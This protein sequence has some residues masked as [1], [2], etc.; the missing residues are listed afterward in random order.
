MAVRAG[1]GGHTCHPSTTWSRQGGQEFKAIL[2]ML[3]QKPENLGAGEGEMV[4][5]LKSA[6]CSQSSLSSTY[7]RQ[8][9]IACSSRGSEA[10]HP[11]L[12]PLPPYPPQLLAQHILWTYLCVRQTVFIIFKRSA[13]T[14]SSKRQLP[15]QMTIL[16][17]CSCLCT[18]MFCL[19]ACMC[20]TCVP[21]DHRVVVNH[22]M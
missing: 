4:P 13:G 12:T 15:P 1:C 19:N 10:S 20:T 22:S 6:Y 14:L 16:N 3:S 17:V 18:W 7:T 11:P 9:T 21:G 5:G 2:E 8:L